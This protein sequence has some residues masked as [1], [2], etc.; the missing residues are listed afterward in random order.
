MSEI[1]GAVKA[2][3]N[4][5]IFERDPDKQARRAAARDLKYT[6]K[7]ILCALKIFRYQKD[8]EDLPPNSKVSTKKR[9]VLKTRIAKEKKSFYRLLAID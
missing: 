6:K 4:F 3:F 5:L 7:A 1:A 9:R 2:F 8:I